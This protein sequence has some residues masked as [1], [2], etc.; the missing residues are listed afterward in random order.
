MRRATALALRVLVIIVLSVGSFF[1]TYEAVAADARTTQDIERAWL[2]KQTLPAADRF[3]TVERRGVQ[4]EVAYRGQEAVGGVFYTEGVGYG[5]LM[6]FMVGLDPPRERW[7][8]SFW[9]RT[10]RP[11]GWGRRSP[12]RYSSRNFVAGAGPL[13]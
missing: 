5:G 11:T 12:I 8:E 1:P 3:E 7:K 10:G 2:L 13:F 6:R 4:Y 9:S